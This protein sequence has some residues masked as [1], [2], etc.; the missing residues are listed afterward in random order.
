MEYN[1]VSDK[2]E[3]IKRK[4]K[5]SDCLNIGAKYFLYG[6]ISHLGNSAED[7]HFIATIRPSLNRWYEFN[8]DTVT[9]VGKKA[10]ESESV[11]E[12]SYLLAYAREDVVKERY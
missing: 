3:K 7:G 8:D 6:I 9:M 12:N 2:I 4:I 1:P 11:Q 10:N 5:I